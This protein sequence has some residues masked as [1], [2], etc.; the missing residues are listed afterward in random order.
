LAVLA[1]GLFLCFAWRYTRSY[2]AWP[3]IQAQVKALLPPDSGHVLAP[4]VLWA[5]FPVDSFRDIGGAV[6]AHYYINV[7]LT[8][9]L[10]AWR[11]HVLIA[12]SSFRHA[13]GL[14]GRDPLKL[15]RMLGRPVQWRG[16]ID[17]KNAYGLWDVYL[18]DWREA[19]R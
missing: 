15:A 2:P 4:N 1:A 3:L 14:T 17:T 12:E 7:P 5:E 16:S 11:P 18:I 19:Q 10:S 8:G 9:L 13:Y 6:T